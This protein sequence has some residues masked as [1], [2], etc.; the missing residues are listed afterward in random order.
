MKRKSLKERKE[1][2]K[3]RQ[4]EETANRNNKNQGFKPILDLSGYDEVEFFKPVKGD[5]R[6]DF[7]PFTITKDWMPYEPGFDDY[8]VDVWVHRN[9][10]PNNDRVICPKT[11]GKAC[12]ICEER[13]NMR[14]QGDDDGA[15]EL[16][17]SLKCLYNVIN[18]D[19]RDGPILIFEASQFLFEKEMLDEAYS[20]LEDDVSIFDPETGLTVKFRATPE[21][22][23]KADYFKFK[24]FKFEER[25]P[26]D[27]S[28][29]EEAY[30]LDSLLVVMDYESLSNLF[31]GIPE[32]PEPTL[33]P[34]PEPEPEKEKPARR[35]RTRP[36][37]E[38]KPEPKPEPESEPMANENQCPS[39]YEWGVDC[40]EKNECQ[41]CPD[42][43]FTRCA[44]EQD[45]IKKAEKE[46]AKEKESPRRG[47]RR[48]V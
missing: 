41:D 6:L 7:I 9:V 31:Y 26:Y 48:R 20:V 40:N 45:R 23:G 39:G 14:D 44:D 43:I 36:T 32:S 2:L 12:P 33:L 21:K 18:A 38:P 47:R 27:D 28:I 10:G 42:D 17:P 16:R 8:K 46:K 19:D 25:E 4:K 15:K 5:N 22:W 24:S 13:K 11:I 3:K 37:S 29:I 1:A 34:K 35:R 30:P